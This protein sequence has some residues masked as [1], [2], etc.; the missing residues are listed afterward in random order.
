M[1]NQILT[2]DDKQLLITVLYNAQNITGLTEYSPIKHYYYWYLNIL[3]LLKS[4]TDNV[5]S[6]YIL[7]DGVDERNQTQ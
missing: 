2:S 7:W 6:S 5:L 3:L 4:N 1:H